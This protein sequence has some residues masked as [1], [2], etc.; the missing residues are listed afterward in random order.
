MGDLAGDFFSVGMALRVPD[1]A[2]A[3]LQ[4]L[5]SGRPEK[6]ILDPFATNVPFLAYLTEQAIDSIVPGTRQVDEI[7]WWIDPTERRRTA[8]SA[9]DHFPGVWDG[10]RA[11]HV[12]GLVDRLLSGGESTL[13][14][15]GEISQRLGVV[16]Q[17][18]EIPLLTRVSSLGGF[19][20]KAVDRWQ[21]EEAL[22]E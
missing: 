5:A 16:V 17:P 10:A 8:S 12:I 14:A 22:R 2:F 21:Y 15:A 1:K 6:P 11:G 20:L 13:P 18:R 19:N 7:I 4:S 3:S 9:L